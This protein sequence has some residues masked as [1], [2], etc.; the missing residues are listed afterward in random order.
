[1]PIKGKRL[2]YFLSLLKQGVI[3]NAYHLSF[4]AARLAGI[5]PQRARGLARGLISTDVHHEGEKGETKRLNEEV[6]KRRRFVK[7]QMQDKAKRVQP[8]ASCYR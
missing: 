8:A 3:I 1:M 7:M 2:W 5:E 4:D 6:E